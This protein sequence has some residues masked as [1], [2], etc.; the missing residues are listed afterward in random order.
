MYV[1]V[2]Y[3]FQVYLC[4]TPSLEDARESFQSMCL[5]VD[6]FDWDHMEHADDFELPP[7]PSPDDIDL[8]PWQLESDPPRSPDDNEPHGEMGN[9]S[10]DVDDVEAAV[11]S[12]CDP[13]TA[14]EI[15]SLRF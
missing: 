4:T 3:T 8:A 10:A 2:F 7:F 15:G 9:A 14:S 1:Y 13:D 12:Q 5:G 11:A 6:R